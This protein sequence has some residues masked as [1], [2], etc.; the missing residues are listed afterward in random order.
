MSSAGVYA[1]PLDTVSPGPDRTGN[2]LVSKQA[3]YNAF[4]HVCFTPDS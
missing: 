1:E 4:S 3:F 2:F